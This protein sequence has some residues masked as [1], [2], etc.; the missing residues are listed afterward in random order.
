[1]QFQQFPNRTEKTLSNFILS[2]V[3]PQYIIHSDLWRSYNNLSS[4]GFIHETVN[5][6]IEFANKKDNRKVIHTQKEDGNWTSN[7]KSINVGI[8]Y[9][10]CFNI[11]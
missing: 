4:L 9:G 2:N 3:Q 11:I 8:S 10:I 7:K 1:M 5:H 6:K